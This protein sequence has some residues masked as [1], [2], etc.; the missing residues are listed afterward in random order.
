MFYNYVICYLNL[1]YK[2]GLIIEFHFEDDNKQL[3]LQKIN[4]LH[5]KPS[6][7]LSHMLIESCKR[8]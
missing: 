4:T 3:S 2:K 6:M 5:G 7:L 1:T 8:S